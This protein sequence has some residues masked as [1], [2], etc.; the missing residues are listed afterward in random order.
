ML[1]FLFKTFYTCIESYT[2]VKDNDLLTHPA[3]T[4]SKRIVLHLSSGSWAP[5]SSPPLPN[6]LSQV[7]VC[8][9]EEQLQGLLSPALSPFYTGAWWGFVGLITSLDLLLLA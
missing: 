9:F 3:L 2:K 5:L 7:P 4:K 6:A 1:S 8:A